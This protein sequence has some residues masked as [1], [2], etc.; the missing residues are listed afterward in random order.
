MAGV[1]KMAGVFLKLAGSVKALGKKDAQV[2]FLYGIVVVIANPRTG[3]IIKKI[4]RRR[5]KILKS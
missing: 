4:V 2:D 1:P 5:A 3:P